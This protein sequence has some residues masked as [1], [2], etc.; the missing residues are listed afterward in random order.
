MV[1]GLRTE[2]G[3]L[4]V[5]GLDEVT[6]LKD[7]DALDRLL[8]VLEAWRNTDFVIASRVADWRGASGKATIQGWTGVDPVELTLEPLGRD[9]VTRFLQEHRGF[10]RADAYE[11]VTDYEKRG[12]D[13]WLGN[14]KTLEML[15]KVAGNKQRPETTS[16]LFHLYVERTWVEPRKQDTPL[17]NAN[18]QEV[19]DALGALFAALIV[20][21]YDALTQAPG[22]TRREGD[23]P[24]AECKQLPGIVDL[25]NDQLS[26]FL[27]SRLVAGAGQD[28]L[29][30]QH[31]RIGEYLGARWIAARANNSE[32]RSRV[33]GAL[34][35]D[36][37]VPSSLRG[38]W[39]WLGGVPELATDVIRADPLAV[40]EYGDADSLDF[41][42]AKALLMALERA[43]DEHQEFGRRDYR[44]AA[45]VKPE[46][47]FEV[48]RILAM[49]S[50]RRFWTQHILLGQMR[51]PEAVL[52]HEETLRALML[53][54]T[55]PSAIRRDAAEALANHGML[56]DWKVLVRQLASSNC[57]DS[58]R[59]VLNLMRNPNVGVTLDDAEFAE[60]VYD[61]SGL[62]P[63]FVGH[64]EVGTVSFYEHG[65]SKVI[66]DDRL[67]GV[68][69][70]LSVCS[71]KYITE[72]TNADAW[73]VKR[74]FLALLRRRLELGDVDADGL[75]RWLKA[76]R[77]SRYGGIR[78]DQEWLDSW[79]QANDQIRRELQ[80][81]LIDSTSEKP[82]SV[83]W[84]F[85][86]VALGLHPSVDDIV[87]LLNWLPIGDTR[88]SEL[89][90]LAPAR[91]EGVR[92]RKAAER[93]VTTEEDRRVL[94]DHADPPP[95]SQDEE[96]LT[97]KMRQKVKELERNNKIRADF[98]ANRERMREGSWGALVGPAEV[99]LGRAYEAKTELSPQD[100]IGAWIG[101]DLQEDAP[102]GFEAFI[103]ADLPNPPTAVQI[104]ESHAES[105]HWPAALI[106]SAALAERHRTG[107][108]FS[109]LS[110]E[111][112][113]AGLFAERVAF[114]DDE[115]WG[116]LRNAL[117]L[118]LERRNAWPETAALFIEPQLRKR[119]TYVSWLWRVLASDAGTE[120]ATK[121]L[122]NFP[123]IPA[124]PE[125][126]LIDQLLRDGSEASRK[127]LVE[128]AR[129][130]RKQSLDEVRKS[131]WQAVELI[132]GTLPLAKLS[133]I[134]AK[135]KQFLW[136]L[137]DRMGSK[138]H[139]SPAIVAEPGLLAATVAS[140]APL[141]P[142]TN[143]PSDVTTGNVNPWDATDFL[144]R[145]LDR[146]A[147]DPSATATTALASLQGVDYGY[148]WKISRSIFDQRRARANSEWRPHKVEAL[149]TLVTDGPPVNHSDFQSLLLAEL[150]VVQ[151][152]I[153]S[154]SEDVW[155]FFYAD[156][157]KKKPHKE[158]QCSDALVSLLKQSDRPLDFD[159]EK[160]LGDDREG[161][162]W[163]K[164]GK[165]EL[166]IECKRHWHADLW[167]AFDW[168]LAQQ[169]AVD[170]RVQSYGIYVIYWFGTQVKPLTGPP[171]RSDVAKPRSPIELEIA[172]GEFIRKAGL[173]GIAVK[174]ID[175]SR[176]LR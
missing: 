108:D 23:L 148:A 13:D 172:L 139:S 135:N 122:R 128:V 140:F 155:R 123:R 26:A 31:R 110:T 65:P 101:E 80:C 71:G 19:L 78:E 5:D 41:S 124:E 163:C 36:G 77:Y 151:A 158:D 30:Y 58:I 9:E 103:T 102:T 131:N 33:L 106:L 165:L 15:A 92:V 87:Y 4:F 68:L 2:Q 112:V 114:L 166:A 34:R 7:G 67:G 146:L 64:R 94:R 48:E 176:S 62:T 12:L 134:A 90:W 109:D 138:R 118:E 141:W 40:I 171:R 99:Y 59:L 86:K 105:R 55:L 113:Q 129:R 42:A 154:S 45:L 37:L 143:H 175:V 152:K 81:K 91:D 56:Q 120:L 173:S 121:W 137:R 70:A 35:H 21:G 14:P 49:P 117:I 125:E 6:G 28:R 126:A 170:W 29:T 57:H 63:R 156:A 11:F 51:D 18:Q 153:S 39:G 85:H 43:E 88:W 74:L 8:G 150:S 38:L 132:L 169:Q 164:Y 17:A 100:R 98:S 27:G 24:I 61:Y 174:V 116:A 79:L 83:W 76:S 60:T 95:L 44:A 145:C 97:R 162:I 46:L 73:E 104:A 89:I 52:R 1:N 133:G 50:N 111:R 144:A 25:T 3:K 82:R 72:E 47:S 75:W 119:L 142:L 66:G 53:N 93:H 16:A 84:Q 20:G 115:K 167:T 149:A 127:A 160:H 168:Q 136:T 107:R 147:A 32:L 69:N 130:R 10:S 161:D 157:V 54:E 96:H 22:A 159:R